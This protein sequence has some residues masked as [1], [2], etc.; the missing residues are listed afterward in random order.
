VDP[1]RGKVGVGFRRRVHQLSLGGKV[2][3]L[4]ISITTIALLVAASG[5]A[6]YEYTAYRNH[7]VD[8]LGILLE[9][10]AKN[11]GAALA[12]SDR[13][14]AGELLSALQVEEAVEAVTLR[15]GEGQAFAKYRFE[16][17]V[18]EIGPAL[19]GS[20]GHVFAHGRLYI[21][22]PVRLQGERVGTLYAR[23]SLSGIHAV[24]LRYG[25]FVMSILACALLVAFVLASR[26]ANVISR[27]VTHLVD[28]AKQIARDQDYRVRAQRL[29][30][31]ELGTLV[32]SF[33]D[34]LAEIEA[35]D[36]E[37]LHAHEVLEDRVD[38][39]TA[40]LK[41]AKELAEEA[42][43]AKSEF[44]ANISHE[45]RTPMH[46]I[47]SFAS[48]GLK[49]ANSTPEQIADFFTKIHLAGGRLLVL[50]NDLLDLSKLEA[51]KMEMSV[52][53]TDLDR[54]LHS[55]VDE[56][57][58]LL[59]ERDIEIRLEGSIGQWVEADGMRIMQVLRN[60][61]GNAVKFSTPGAEITVTA[62]VRD[63]RAHL[64]VEDQGVGV[65]DDEVE[66]VF[67]KF[68]QSKKT[69]T[70]AGGTGLG[71]SIC[72]EIVGAHHGRVWAQPGRAVG[73]AF[74]VELP[75]MQPRTE[76]PG[77]DWHA[78]REVKRPDAREDLA[79]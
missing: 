39:R 77:F 25:I 38:L 34:M 23:V 17:P 8:S 9:V 37:L 36:S 68:V 74:H 69:K 70:G 53:P 79:A 4:A 2:R 12:F 41:V 71:L 65:P 62:G 66:T 16:F 14:A 28:V 1:A 33:N 56:F 78:Q 58:S 26:M 5:L 73:A 32:D 20:G 10:T 49:R 3:L 64:V 40:E 27:P 24:L 19:A 29:S 52:G 51:G 42:S 13:R 31:D 47:L 35:R 30:E 43:L 57:R 45:L 72:R 50:L 44:L 54:V 76:Q 67:D 60:L 18:S 63:G 59:S 75:V 15:D 48:F 22:R 7:M 61:L 6:G 46:A 21:V 55:V 11:A